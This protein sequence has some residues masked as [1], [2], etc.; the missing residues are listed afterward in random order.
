MMEFHMIV[1]KLLKFELF[2]IMQKFCMKLEKNLQD[3]IKN[4]QDNNEKI[5]RKENKHINA[6]QIDELNVIKF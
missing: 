3:I 1:I 2:Y 6:I 5:N 4:I